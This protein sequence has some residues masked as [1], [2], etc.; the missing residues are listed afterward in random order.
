V[1][2]TK[3]GGEATFGL[4]SPR[5]ELRHRALPGCARRGGPQLSFSETETP[6]LTSRR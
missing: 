2:L 4:T 3:L 5:G 6:K 1:T